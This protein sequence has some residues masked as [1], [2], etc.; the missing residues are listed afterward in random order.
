MWSP[1]AWA[2]AGGQREADTSRRWLL[3]L[4]RSPRPAVGSRLLPPPPPPVLSV[5]IANYS[6]WI[7]GSEP[8]FLGRAEHRERMEETRCQEQIVIARKKALCSSLAFTT[9]GTPGR[10]NSVKWWTELTMS[11]DLLSAEQPWGERAGTVT[12][13]QAFRFPIAELQLVGSGNPCSH[14][15]LFLLTPSSSPL[16]IWTPTL[17]QVPCSRVNNFHFSR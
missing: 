13:T 6:R 7:E 5:V 4:G 15:A 11:T 1:S 8:I 9:A 10:T 16:F 14:L 17:F 12:C 3:L 2:L